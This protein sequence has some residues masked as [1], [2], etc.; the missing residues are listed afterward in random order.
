MTWQKFIV[1]IATWLSK[2]VQD[3]VKL[4]KQA[5]GTSTTPS[6]Q[7]TATGTNIMTV[8]IQLVEK[9]YKIILLIL[10]ILVILGAANALFSCSVNSRLSSDIQQLRTVNTAL[11]GDV[12]QLDTS[13]TASQ[14]LVTSLSGDNDR[15][16]KQLGASLAYSSELRKQLADS[17]SE[18]AGLRSQL[19]GITGYVGQVTSDD[20]TA[21]GLIDSVTED[22][23]RALGQ[24]SGAK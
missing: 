12:K 24:N 9:H 19:N 2:L 1:Q 5:R 4:F 8:I 22:I 17:R 16:K 3:A 18:A 6:P 20:S 13:L 15:L 14:S 11:A 21:K 10:G 23:Q 7:T